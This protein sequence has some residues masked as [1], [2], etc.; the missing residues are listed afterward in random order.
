MNTDFTEQEFD[1]MFDN[2]L[3]D[4][5][6]GSVEQTYDYETLNMD[7]I[8]SIEGLIEDL[9][10]DNEELEEEPVQEEIEEELEQEEQDD[11]DDQG[12]TGN[13]NLANE[14]LDALELERGHEVTTTFSFVGNEGEP[15]QEEPADQGVTDNE[16]DVHEHQFTIIMGT[17]NEEMLSRFERATNQL[18]LE[19]VEPEQVDVVIFHL[20]SEQEQGR[21]IN[22]NVARLSFVD[23]RSMVLDIENMW[24]ESEE[25]GVSVE[26]YLQQDLSEGIPTEEEVEPEPVEELE[27]LEEDEPVVEEEQ[28][29]VRR[30]RSSRG[31][32]YT[33]AWDIYSLGY[34]SGDVAYVYNL[35]AGSITR[36]MKD[37]G[38]EMRT[39]AETRAMRKVDP[40][41]FSQ[42]LLDRIFNLLEEKYE[43]EEERNTAFYNTFN[44]NIY[45]LTLH[46]AED[47]SLELQEMQEQANIQGVTLQDYVSQGL[48][49]EVY[50]ERERSE[51]VNNVR[52]L[53]ET[54]KDKV[55][56]MFGDVNV[57]VGTVDVESKVSYENGV[58]LTLKDSYKLD[59]KALDVSNVVFGVQIAEFIV[60]EFEREIEELINEMGRITR[61]RFNNHSQVTRLGNRLVVGLDNE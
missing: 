61:E 57:D 54:V 23:L 16:N 28:Q 18:L 48:A 34:A 21:V 19:L 13:S 11:Q 15:V 36:G 5:V 9:L 30:R 26:Q 41:E 51:F 35:S 25:H 8:E 1:S 42:E 29:P 47:E 20:L 49:E 14:I 17:N 53:H 27:P 32:D 38:N 52:Y 4:V 58:I 12:V 22:H 2:L 7:Y 39:G 59:G 46:E 56:Y 33:L 10:G 6:R 45:E 60:Q 24:S 3:D 31:N 37:L 40:D 55:R 44:K 50:E 43:T